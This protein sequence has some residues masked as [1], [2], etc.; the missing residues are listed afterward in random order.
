MKSAHGG[1]HKPVETASRMQDRHLPNCP[2]ASC[3]RAIME[4]SVKTYGHYGGMTADAQNVKLGD[5]ITTIGGGI[6]L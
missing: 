1:P 6:G 2:P 3:P 4:N 5:I